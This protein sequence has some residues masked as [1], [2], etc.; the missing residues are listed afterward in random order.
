MPDVYFP[1]DPD[2]PVSVG[3]YALIAGDV[4]T[5]ERASR[6]ALRANPHSIPARINLAA[7]LELSGNTHEALLE[8]LEAASRSRSNLCA[9]VALGSAF[10]RRKRWTLALDSYSRAREV[11]PDD[12]DALRGLGEVLYQMDSP[13]AARAH[14]ERACVIRTDDAEI[15]NTAGRVRLALGDSLGA[16]AAYRNAAQLKPGDCDIHRYLGY[17]L[18]TCGDVAG[19]LQ[20]TKRSVELNPRAP[21]SHWAL[22]RMLSDWNRLD[23]AL[24]HLREAT[25]LDP[26]DP[27]YWFDLALAEERAGHLLASRHALNMALKLDGDY[28]AGHPEL[29]NLATRI[30]HGLIAMERANVQD[31]VAT[32]PD[33]FGCEQCRITPSAGKRPPIVRK[34]VIS[35][36]G[37]MQYAFA[38]CENCRQ[39]YLEL[40]VGMTDSGSDAHGEG[41]A[42]VPLL[43]REVD[44]VDSALALATK[45]DRPALL[46]RL[47]RARRRLVEYP[48]GSFSWCE[49][50]VEE[51]R[52]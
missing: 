35:P 8:Y 27:D 22:G 6:D 14:I 20:E 12:P 37:Q 18:Y 43:G 21:L 34:R 23:E 45:S 11:A 10:R 7:A 50:R 38:L 32:G 30:D 1:R 25:L 51:V 15:W 19:A 41:R 3:H 26:D 17:A 2:N 16:V 9:L 4:A 48:L 31:V 24:F 49:P 44:E 46:D 13:A 33:G 28:A 42:W 52:A 36:P 40:R 47:M 5:A 29:N 39:T